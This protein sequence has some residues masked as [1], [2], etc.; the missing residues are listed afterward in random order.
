MLQDGIIR[1]SNNPYSS[2]AILV[3]KKDG[4]WR[5][6]IDYEEL[7]SQTIKDKFP[8]PVIEDLLDEL[9]GAKIFTKLDLR[10]GYHQIKIHDPGI[11]KIA[12]R[13]TFGQYEFVVMP[14]VLTNAPATFH[15]L[16][17]H[18]F[19]AQLRKFV[20]VFFDD[21]LIYSR[22][23]ADHIAHL[24]QVLS[25]LRA[26]KLTAKESKCI[27][28]THRVEYLGHVITVVGVSTDPS[29]IS[30]IQSWA[31]PKI[32]TRLRGFLGLTGYY[33]RFI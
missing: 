9:H 25:I 11:H 7:N 17:N 23:M 22:T 19:E 16:M 20:L 27:F 6:C 2:P 33:R 32:V 8:I 14:F 4:S 21:I 13:T 1:P 3:R 26:N 24:H 18:I 12:F 29:K 15:S 10:S 5:L 30:A 28:A 31:I